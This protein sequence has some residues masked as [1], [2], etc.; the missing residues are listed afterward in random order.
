[1][2]GACLLQADAF[3]VTFNSVKVRDK[4]ETDKCRENHAC[5]HACTHTLYSIWCRCENR[6]AVQFVAEW[7]HSRAAR[8][9]GRVQQRCVHAYIL[10]STGFDRTRPAGTEQGPCQLLSLGTGWW[11]LCCRQPMSSERGWPTS[12]NHESRRYTE[13]SYLDSASILGGCR[14]SSLHTEMPTVPDV[15]PTRTWW[16]VWLRPSTDF[17]TGRWTGWCW[18]D[19]ISRPSTRHTQR[20]CVQKCSDRRADSACRWQDSAAGC[21]CDICR[22]TRCGWFSR[23]CGTT[24][25]SLWTG[26]RAHPVDSCVPPAPATCHQR[27]RRDMQWEVQMLRWV[28]RLFSL[29]Q[30]QQQQQ[31]Q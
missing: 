23:G 16:C 12:T 28:E 9:T 30:Q 11:A 3:P 27:S 24:F 17:L 22:Q 26:R 14:D 5:T 8:T 1:M 15:S 18:N 13:P 19:L 6:P 4:T 20:H 29:H 10:P 31:Q 2:T 25:R 21:T 7:G